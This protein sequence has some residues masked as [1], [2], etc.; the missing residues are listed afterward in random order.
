MTSSVVAYRRT[1]GIRYVG[2]VRDEFLKSL[3][4]KLGVCGHGC[5]QVIHIRLVMLV[6]VQVH[7]S[8]VKA[9][10]ER[11]ITVGQGR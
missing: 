11:V 3:S 4:S 6:V 5:I 1:G 2:K 8:R 7:G 9:G 10:L